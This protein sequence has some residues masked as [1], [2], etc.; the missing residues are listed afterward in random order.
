M[1]D[2][3]L[4]CLTIYWKVSDHMKKDFKLIAFVLTAIILI[5]FGVFLF[6]KSLNN[7]SQDKVSYAENSS[8]D[9]KVYLKDNSYFDTPYLDEDKV[10]ITSLI[11]YLDINFSYDMKLDDKRSGKRE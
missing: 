1:L 4:F 8:V 2:I 10:Y 9:Y 6:N 5:V 7:Y 3:Q 11:D